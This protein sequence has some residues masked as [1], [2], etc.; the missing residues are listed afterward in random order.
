LRA[1]AAG[2]Q[3]PLLVLPRLHVAS[4]QQTPPTHDGVPVQPTVHVDPVS[5]VTVP[6]HESGPLHCTWHVS[7]WQLM[8]PPQA[9]SPVPQVTSHSVPAQSIWLQAFAASHWM[10]QRL[11]CVQSMP[12]WHD[13]GPLQM[14]L[15]GM[16]GGH[17]M[18]VPQDCGPEQLTTHVPSAAQ[19][20]MP[21]CSHSI[22][23]F[24]S[25]GLPASCAPASGKEPASLPGTPP[26]PPPLDPPLLELAP[27]DPPPLPPLPPLLLLLL[28][29]PPPLLLAP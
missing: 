15:H 2:D 25:V 11:A 9:A 8:S 23:H 21:A 24:G 3:Q 18:A 27:P 6:L 7:A 13:V 20:P 1:Q 16:P 28:P 22:L 29:L 26:D 14:T 12:P 4:L 5:H 17:V 19:V 10:L